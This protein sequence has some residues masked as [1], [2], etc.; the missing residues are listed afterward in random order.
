M[1]E[2]RL[3]GPDPALSVERTRAALQEVVSALQAPEVNQRVES[4]LAEA[5][6]DPMKRVMILSPIVLDVEKDVIA[7][8]G[9]TADQPGVLR[10]LM[11]VKQYE[12]V[13]EEIKRLYDFLKAKFLPP[14]MAI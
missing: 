6:D 9:F 10:F 4:G 12:S 5:G 14:G 1:E 2:G 7:R 11:L 13:D 8:Y 3:D